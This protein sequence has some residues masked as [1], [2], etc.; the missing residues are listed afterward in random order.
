MSLILEQNSN[1]KY[2]LKGKVQTTEVNR[3][4]RRYPASVWESLHSNPDFKRRLAKGQ[5]V[6]GLGHPKDGRFDPM[7]IGIVLR[8]QYMEGND[9]MG[10]HEVLPTPTG[11]V[12]K[13]LYESGVELGISSRGRDDNSRMEN[14][15]TVVSDDFYL[16]G[17]DVVI[18]PSVHDAEPVGLSESVS[19]SP[20]KNYKT[21]VESRCASA[22]VTRT[23]VELYQDILE[24][25]FQ[26]KESSEYQALNTVLTEA[27]DPSR[28]LKEYSGLEN[29]NI[30]KIPNTM[31]KIQKL[32]EGQEVTVE[33]YN[34]LVEKYSA[35]VQ[36]EEGAELETTKNALTEANGKY[37]KLNTEHT[38]MAEELAQKTKELSAAKQL[39]GAS[40]NR[41]HVAESAKVETDRKLEASI[42]IIG[43]LQKD[44][45]V[46]ES[47]K[48]ES[49]IEESVK[50]VPADK[51]AYVRNVLEASDSVESASKLFENVKSLF[52]A[53]VTDPSLP[54]GKKIEESAKDNPKKSTVK[55]DPLVEAM[56]RNRNKA[57]A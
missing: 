2:F 39:I 18:E 11:N 52:P 57:T 36:K 6:G 56:N 37:E 41:I 15:I 25:V 30:P 45:T 7:Q 20:E 9:I 3:N 21:L 38:A 5:I 53:S 55:L 27:L 22:D 49:F 31:S 28:G 50:S 23:E 24:S 34:T 1:G 32:T 51:Q 4:R 29:R 8:E 47:S 48:L 17:Y 19:K 46:S 43:E 42:K 35:M 16:E 10:S 33:A 26:D 14:G 54:N 13:T 40:L 44:A 12:I